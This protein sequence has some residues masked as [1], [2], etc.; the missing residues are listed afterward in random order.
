MGWMPRSIEIT[1]NTFKRS[2]R[3]IPDPF[4]AGSARSLSSV[5]GAAVIG[6]NRTESD[7]PFQRL[8][9]RGIHNLT[10]SHNVIDTW[11]RGP[12]INIGDATGVSIQNNT[13]SNPPQQLSVPLSA[14]SFAPAIAI[15]DA[16]TVAVRDNDLTGGWLSIADAIRVEANST[17]RVTV[18]GTQLHRKNASPR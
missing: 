15:S 10:I 11:F 5:I 12:A 16:E 8:L 6:P 1:G 14:A 17:K 7:E 13:I 18:V 2:S 4:H 3:C 9:L